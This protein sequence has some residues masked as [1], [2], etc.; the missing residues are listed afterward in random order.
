MICFIN[1]ETQRNQLFSKGGRKVKIV[2]KGKVE[3]RMRFIYA[4]V[5]SKRTETDAQMYF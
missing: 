1:A 4:G 3:G 5:K 2:Y